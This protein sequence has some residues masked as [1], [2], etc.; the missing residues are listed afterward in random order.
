M[1]DTAP[2]PTVVP[3]SPAVAEA[4]NE[5]IRNDG[6]TPSAR[7]QTLTADRGADPRLSQNSEPVRAIPRQADPQGQDRPQP[8]RL[9]DIR[10]GNKDGRGIFITQIYAVQSDEYA[11]Y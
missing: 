1:A 11:I 10:V 5:G 7:E 2:E 3:I 8:F 6:E 4:I 9:G